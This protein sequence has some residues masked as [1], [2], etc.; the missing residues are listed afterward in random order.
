MLYE[1]VEM[2]TT[3]LYHVNLNFVVYTH[4]DF[5][6]GKL[7]QSSVFFYMTTFY[8]RRLIHEL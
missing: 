8:I 7:K 5:L 4:Q 2:K 6:L 3:E 1:F